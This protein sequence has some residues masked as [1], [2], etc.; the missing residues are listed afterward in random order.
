MRGEPRLRGHSGGGG[1]YCPYD[2]PGSY[3]KVLILFGALVLVS[4][5][6]LSAAS[7]ARAGAEPPGVGFELRDATVA[8][9][10]ALFAGPR[11]VRLRFSFAARTPT[12]VTI[13]AIG[14]RDRKVVASWQERDLRPGERHLIRWD[15]LNR[16]DRAVPDG[17]YEFRAGPT[18]SQDRFAGSTYLRGYVFPVDGPHGSRGAIGDFGAPRSGGRVHEGFDITAD[19]GTRL[20]ASRGGTIRDV[21]YDPVLYGYYVLIDGRET[22]R[23]FFYSHLIAP[24]PVRD[25]EEVVT[26]QT[27]GAVG[28]TGNAASTPCHLHFEV[29]LR[30][31]P[32]DP[33]PLLA[34]WA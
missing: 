23:D 4:G 1:A 18:G 15:G 27:V 10:Q 30:G 8:P 29:R 34:D 11:P 25:G 26:G 16:R 32:V 9:K 14:A 31:R 7:P 6:G 2:R 21:G 24:P 20:V 3:M 19:C 13:L 12:D 5:L 28:Q 17:R 33:K 22:G